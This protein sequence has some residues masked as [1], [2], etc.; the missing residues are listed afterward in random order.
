MLHESNAMHSI[1]FGLDERNQK[2]LISHPANPHPDH[3]LTTQ[4]ASGKSVLSKSTTSVPAR[5]SIKETIAARKK[6]ANAGKNLPSRPGSAE[7]L[8]SPK[9]ST[10]QSVL[11]RPATAMST[12]SRNVST[13]SVGT[14]SS[15]PVR[16][17]RRADIARPATADPYGNRKPARIETPPRSPAASPVKRVKTP[18]PTASTVKRANRKA[19]SPNSTVSLKLN[20]TDKLA[21]PGEVH[22]ADSTF[23]NIQPQDSPTKAAEDFT[24]VI[25]NIKSHADNCIPRNRSPQLMRPTPSPRMAT[26]DDP[27]PPASPSSP[28]SAGSPKKISDANGAPPDDMKS[29]MDSPKLAGNFGQ[30]SINVNNDQRISMSPRSINSRKENIILKDLYAQEQRP[31]K[32]YEDPVHESS[33]GNSYPSPLTHT[34]RALEELPVN[35]PAKNRQA[36]DHQLLGEESQSPEY[37]QKWLAVEA[38]ERRRISASENMENP[39]MARKI[40]DSVIER[41]RARTLDVHGFRKLQALIRSSGDSIWEDGYKFDELIL[42]LLE[43]LE[44]PNDDA[45]LRSGKAPDLKTQDLVTVRLL[46]Q[47]QPKYFA[48][49]YPRALTAVLTARKHYNSTS[50]IVCGLE[51][52]AESVVQQCDP[53]PCLDAVLDLL[54]EKGST[55]PAETNTISMALYVLAGL[56]HRGQEKNSPRQLSD[57]QEAKLGS[58]AARFLAATNPDIRRAVIEFVLEFH[59]T[60]DDGRFWSLVAGGR[61]DHRSLITYYLARKRAIAQ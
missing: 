34:P 53:P 28:R 45:T 50:H 32:V 26:L 16:P 46:L 48:D 58:T 7:P 23:A 51:E 44:L 59:D 35:E 1:L 36:L 38:A 43:Y 39:R 55:N 2:A 18:A 33:Y 8:G 15:A 42:P 4:T 12:A 47:H 24:M 54:V 27:F 5:P 57:D 14:L 52:T 49:Y 11:G 22:L 61:D 20:S 25:P 30:L 40:L 56:L 41:V 19:D 6:A 10:S 13:T 17:R 3:V 37:H 31:L 60:I 29:W 21:N 9:K